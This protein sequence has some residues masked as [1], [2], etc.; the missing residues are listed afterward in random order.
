MIKKRCSWVKEG[1]KLY[2]KYHDEEWGVPL[3][4]DKKIFEF[5]VL[6]SAQAGLSWRTILGRREGYKRA[7]KN[8]DPKKVSKMN[9]ADVEGLLNTKQIIRNRKKIDAAIN[10]AKRFL[11]VQKEFKSFAKYIWSFVENT[12]LQNN[13]SKGS[14]VPATT[15]IS[16][17]L[18]KDMKKRGFTF[19]GP[20]ILYAHM[21][22]TGMVNDHL[23]TCF[24]Y[25]ECAVIAKDFKVV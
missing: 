21:Q 19:L 14:S 25:K 24:R 11:E 23:K 5:L 18:A 4:E 13:R 6:E 16:E 20:T 1:D 22:A 9:Q 8:F 12:P 17:K 10:N 3:T 7:F 2:E 15:D